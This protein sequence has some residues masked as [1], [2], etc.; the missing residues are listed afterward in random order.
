[1]LPCAS[2]T[3]HH[4]M[5]ETVVPERVTPRSR[6]LFYEML[7]ISIAIHALAGGSLMA[8][9]LWTVVFPPQPPKMYAAYQ[10]I[11]TPTPPPP[12]PPPPAVRRAPVIPQARAVPVKMPLVAPTVI[13]DLIPEV[14]EEV[15]Y[16]ETP[17]AP[18]ANEGGKPGG[19]EGGIEGGETDG[20]LGGVPAGLPKMPEPEII[21]VQRDAPLPMGAIS[22]E[23]PAYPEFAWKRMWE[24][25]LVVRY[26][27]GKDG[28]VKEVIVLTPPERDEFRRETVNKIKQWRFHPYIGENGEPKEVQHELTVEFRMVRK[29]KK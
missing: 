25:T 8:S 15:P 29:G 14:V 12:P 3:N 27:I 20:Q 2:T 1:M 18:V 5:F 9:A 4:R 22:Q 16:V 21:E 19:V 11:A 28:R 17:E 26:T 6:K 7:P 10:L 23:Y 13:P 24:D